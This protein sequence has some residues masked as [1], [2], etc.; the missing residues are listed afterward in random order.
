MRQ[1]K[2]GGLRGGASP[3]DV[4]L[5]FLHTPVCSALKD[6][7]LSRGFQP[8]SCQGEG[9]THTVVTL[10]KKQRESEKVEIRKVE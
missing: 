4:E 5:L 10:L 2:G 1:P 6:P 9:D 3:T 7:A 8:I